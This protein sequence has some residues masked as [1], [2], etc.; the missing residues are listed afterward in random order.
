MQGS[1]SRSSAGAGGGEDWVPVWCEAQSVL[2]QSYDLHPGGC[3]G[4]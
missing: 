2:S 1:D 4:L 3:G